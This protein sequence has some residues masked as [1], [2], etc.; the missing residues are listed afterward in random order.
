MRQRSLLFLVL[1][2]GL[3]GCIG[4]PLGGSAPQ[5]RPVYINLTNEA[6]TSHTF[7]LWVAEAPLDGVQVYMA[8]RSD[9]TVNMGDVG[10]GT[11][12]TGDHQITSY[13]TFPDRATLYGRY[14]LDPTGFRHGPWPNRFLTPC[15]SSSSIMMT[16]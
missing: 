3:T 7:E 14:T 10:I 2:L 6:N 1:L 4:N 12:D 13:L 15:L 5:D 16:R 9:Y 8:N 11:H